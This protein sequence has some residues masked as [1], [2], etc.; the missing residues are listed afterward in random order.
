MILVVGATGQLGGMIT[1]LLRSQ[2]EDVRVLVRGD[3]DYAGLEAAG[4]EP[5]QGD[6]KDA[7]SLVRACDG[8][9]RVITTANSARRGGKDNV[10]AVEIEGNRNLI[11]AAARAD[12][13]QFVFVSAFGAQPHS[14]SEFA[15]GKAEAERY[16][17]GSG[18]PYTILKANVFMEVWIG[19]IVAA[20]VQER[21]AVTV[22][23][24]GLRKHSFV[25]IQDVASF[26]VAV[27]RQP[28]ALNRTLAIGGPEPISWRDIVQLAE[29]MIGRE[30]PLRHVAPGEPLP[31]LPP[32]VSGLA[33]AFDAF[34]SP[35]EMDETTRTY[36]VTLTPVDVVLSRMLAGA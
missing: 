25:S 36:D 21:R 34:D 22:V 5:V 3:S 30:I 10:Q 17:R 15:R 4:A 16:L 14:P 29:Q 1:R 27:L 18:V 6:L 23:G 20:P 32:V 35:I 13:E 12:V 26:A 31:G 11:N 9:E 7:G 28:Q 19:M 2:G 8:V 24:E 33:A